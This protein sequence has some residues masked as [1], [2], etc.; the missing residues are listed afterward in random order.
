M[1]EWASDFENDVASLILGLS[2]SGL[3]ATPFGDSVQKISDL[4]QNDMMPKVT[5][6][7]E[8]EQAQL[9]SLWN[10]IEACNTV[11]N[12][13]Q[14]ASDALEQ[15][16]V[17]A[18]PEHKDCREREAVAWTTKVE[19]H[20]QWRDA[21]DQMDL[22]C[23][24]YDAKKQDLRDEPQNQNL[25]GF[26]TA[27]DV[28]TYMVRVSNAVC[29]HLSHQFDCGMCENGGLADDEG[30]LGGWSHSG[31]GNGEDCSHVRTEH[32][33]LADLECH[34]GF[35]DSATSAYNTLTNEVDTADKAWS[36]TNGECGLS[37][38]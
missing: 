34:K 9:D 20:Q 16:Y 27:E 10:D 17:T 32:G 38:A 35:C 12:N 22:K 15:L 33:M 4:I 7:H 31:S 37:A 2:G 1:F 30:G 28:H 6:A 36:Q 23:Q 29:G 8:T 5:S 3:A 26:V 11:K 13:E 25:M 14:T 24:A 18:S 19:K 21:K